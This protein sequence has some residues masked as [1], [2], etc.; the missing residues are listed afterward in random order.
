MWTR[1]FTEKISVE[2]FGGKAVGLC[3]LVQAGLSV[4]A[5]FAV[6]VGFDASATLSDIG[7]ADVLSQAFAESGL[8]LGEKVA[9]RSSAVGEDSATDSF[10]GIYCSMLNVEAE[11]GQL[12]A[13]MREIKARASSV[14]S[15]YARRRRLPERAN[16]VGFVIQRMVYADFLGKLMTLRSSFGRSYVVEKIDRSENLTSVIVT[17]RRDADRWR[18]TGVAPKWLQDLVAGVEKIREI[19]PG[20]QDVEW[21]VVGD[22]T[23][24]LQSRLLTES[25]KA[26][27]FTDAVYTLPH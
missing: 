15:E 24:F 26:P 7:R 5:G 11:T 8:D 27:R 3:R 20:D 13:A 16:D 19:L 4:P 1:C 22:D 21:A 9:V 10:A 17:S 14:S 12:I 18:V 25:V 23:W 6:R 2:D